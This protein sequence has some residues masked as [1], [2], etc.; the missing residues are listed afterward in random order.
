[1]ADKIKLA[2][3]LAIVAA[4]MVA[5]YV[6]STHPLLFR[7]LGLVVA[8]IIATVISAKTAPGASAWEFMRGATIEAR[9]VV[10]PTRKETTQVTVAV[11]AMVGVMGL[12]LWAFDLLL[13]WGIRIMTG[14]GG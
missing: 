3:A 1:M 4:A 12:I 7:V 13:A 9:K 8:V 6:F 11:V 2:L 14:Q 5:F 10:W